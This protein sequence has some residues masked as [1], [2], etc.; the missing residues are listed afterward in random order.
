MVKH[1]TLAHPYQDK[2]ITLGHSF[3]TIIE[4]YTVTVMLRQN[5]S[6][7]KAQTSTVPIM[8]ETMKSFICEKH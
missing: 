6:L 2:A 5:L 7:E 4:Q 8:L 3:Y 1:V